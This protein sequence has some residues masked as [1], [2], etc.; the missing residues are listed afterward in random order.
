M[1]MLHVYYYGTLPYHII[2]LWRQRPHGIRFRMRTLAHC[3]QQQPST[4]SHMAT[5]GVS[6]KSTGVHHYHHPGSCCHIPAG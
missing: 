1:R 3:P 5:F 4:V 6:W 2:L